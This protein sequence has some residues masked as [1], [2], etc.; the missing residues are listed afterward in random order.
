[1]VQIPRQKLN[2]NN[3]STKN[4]ETNIQKKIKLKICIYFWSDEKINEQ[5]NMFN[6]KV[7]L[8]IFCFVKRE[9]FKVFHTRLEM[10]KINGNPLTPIRWRDCVKG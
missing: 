10:A 1:M 4:V 8:A 6:Y 2:T 7:A 9:T 5:I 3:M